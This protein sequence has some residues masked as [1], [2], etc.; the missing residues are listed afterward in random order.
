V[1]NAEY[2]LVSQGLTYLTPVWSNDQWELFSVRDAVPIAARPDRLVDAD[3][4]ELVI[5]VPRASTVPLR[6]RWS[7]S[8]EA[9]TRLGVRVAVLPDGHGWSVLRAS[10]AGRVTITG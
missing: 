1:E 7:A 3:Q 5:D 8:L 2:Q 4:N 9:A 6:V 10:G